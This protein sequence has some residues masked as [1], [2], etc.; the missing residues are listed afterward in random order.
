[1]ISIVAGLAAQTALDVDWRVPFDAMRSELDRLL[2]D[3][4]LWDR[5]V[6]VL[7]VTD[8]VGSVIRV[9]VLVSAPDAGAL[10]GLRCQ[11]REGLVVWLHREHAYGLPRVRWENGAGSAAPAA[12]TAVRQTAENS[13]LFTGSADA[14]ERSRAFTGPSDE[15]IADRTAEPARAR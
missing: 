12:P 7:Q 3:H 6:G 15:E 8:A 2:A 5:R 13:A 1:V 10:F 4:P 14:E 9:R 11:V